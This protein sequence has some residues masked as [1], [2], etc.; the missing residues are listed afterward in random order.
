MTGEDV[1]GRTLRFAVCSAQQTEGL[2]NS[3]IRLMV[4]G[5]I[6]KKEGIA[7]ARS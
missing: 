2:V 6:V 7:L 3:S 1:G 5:Q 4:E